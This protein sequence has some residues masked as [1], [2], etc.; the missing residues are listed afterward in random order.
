MGNNSSK[1]RSHNKSSSSEQPLASGR[2]RSLKPDLAIIM[3]KTFIMRSCIV[4]ACAMRVFCTQSCTTRF[5]D[6]YAVVYSIMYSTC[7]CTHKRVFDGTAD[8]PIVL[9]CL[10]SNF[11]SFVHVPEPRIYAEPWTVMN[12]FVLRPRFEYPNPPTQ[13]CLWCKSRTTRCPSFVYTLTFLH[14]LPLFCT[15]L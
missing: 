14:H 13:L 4:H 1:R 6:A 5:V 9:F 2:K 7:T 8:V 15:C 3:H 10:Y 11:L 12:S